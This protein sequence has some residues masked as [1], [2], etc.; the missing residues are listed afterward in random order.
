MHSSS[1]DDDTLEKQ[2]QQHREMMISPLWNV[3][4]APSKMIFH[5]QKVWYLSSNFTFCQSCTDKPPDNN[6]TVHSNHCLV[7]ARRVGCK[8]IVVVHV[9]VVIKVVWIRKK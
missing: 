8:D 5:C 9:L 1:D 6:T 2:Q 4:W 3:V 7:N